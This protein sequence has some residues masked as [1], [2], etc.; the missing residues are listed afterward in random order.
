MGDSSR[1]VIFPSSFAGEP[2]EN[3]ISCMIIIKIN[4]FITHKLLILAEFIANFFSRFLHV[5]SNF[6]F[7]YFLT[8]FFFL[9]FPIIFTK[10]PLNL[11]QLL[12]DQNNL[13]GTEIQTEK[14]SM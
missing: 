6:R 3:G 4:T 9:N 12:K 5:I 7:F 11:F 13:Y 2:T 10:L 8:A 14:I 1:K